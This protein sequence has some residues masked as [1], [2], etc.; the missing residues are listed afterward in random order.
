MLK[1]NPK[2]NNLKLNN[3]INARNSINGSKR[4]QWLNE[5]D[6]DIIN[7]RGNVFFYDFTTNEKR[8]SPKEILE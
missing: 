7:V 4:K 6:N 3:Q 2:Q 1:A 5:Y 8:Q